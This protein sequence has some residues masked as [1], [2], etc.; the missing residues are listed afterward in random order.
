MFTVCKRSKRRYCRRWKIGRSYHIVTVDIRTKCRTDMNEHTNRNKNNDSVNNDIKQ[1]T[2]YSRF[3]V[4][5]YCPIQ[6]Y[7]PVMRSS[8]TVCPNP[9]SIHTHFTHTPP[10]QCTRRHVSIG[11]N[12]IVIKTLNY[13]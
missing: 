9:S 12:I 11:I 6:C 8:C 3:C 7:S 10:Y 2:Y 5:V 13:N 1:H 4:Y